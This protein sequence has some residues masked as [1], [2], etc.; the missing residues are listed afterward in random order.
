VA[1]LSPLQSAIIVTG[2]GIVLRSEN[3]EHLKRLGHVV[4]LQAEED[5]LFKRA[6]RRGNRP[7]LATDDPRATLIRILVERGPLYAKAAD[8][9]VDTT[10][11]DHEQVADLILAEIESRAASPNQHE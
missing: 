4:W 8:I 2:G 1:S 5:I 9:Q 11:R 10:D 3:I 6:A 7:L